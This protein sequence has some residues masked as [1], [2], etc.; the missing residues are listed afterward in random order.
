MTL[1]RFVAR[2]RDVLNRFHVDVERARLRHPGLLD[3]DQPP[4]VW[5]RSLN[6]FIRQEVTRRR[7]TR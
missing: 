5:L 2:M 3:S 1:E 7:R 4:E 6:E